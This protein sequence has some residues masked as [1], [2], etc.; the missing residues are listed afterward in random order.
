MHQQFIL[1]SVDTAHVNAIPQMHRQHWTSSAEVFF[2]GASLVV[3]LAALCV[4]QC[5]RERAQLIAHLQKQNDALIEE[6]RED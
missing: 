6:I 3:A 4:R 1:V 5:L 2:G